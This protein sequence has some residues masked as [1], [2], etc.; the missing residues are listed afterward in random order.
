MLGIGV[1]LVS[2]SGILLD[3]L[4]KR[5]TLF[6][7]FLLGLCRGEVDRTQ[8]SLESGL[9]LLDLLAQPPAV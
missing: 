6:V 2:G 5:L 1:L 3:S 4:G 9:L 8:I 7:G